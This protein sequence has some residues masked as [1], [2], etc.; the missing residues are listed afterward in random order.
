MA[1]RRRRKLQ[2]GDEGSLADMKTAQLPE[3]VDFKLCEGYTT[4]S[5]ELLRISLLVLSGLATLWVKTTIPLPT[6]LRFKVSVI[7]AAVSLVLSAFAA[8]THRFTAMDS[9]AYHVAAMRLRARNLPARPEKGDIKARKS[10]LDLAEEEVRARNW[11][12]KASG[13]LLLASAFLLLLG[14][15]FS[16]VGMWILRQS[17]AS[18]QPKT[19]LSVKTS[20]QRHSLEQTSR[21]SWTFGNFEGRKGSTSLRPWVS[22]KLGARCI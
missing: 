6:T 17:A 4:Y 16:L 5:A 21:V 3:D 8:L 15:S 1:S 12:F 18:P 10:D 9:M 7:G 11:R 20:P 19:S 2:P 22:T 13:R 14:V